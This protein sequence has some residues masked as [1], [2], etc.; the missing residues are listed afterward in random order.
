[1][2]NEMQ[3][4]ISVLSIGTR[5]LLAILE[6]IVIMVNVLLSSKIPKIKGWLY[7][8]KKIKWDLNYK[9]LQKS[10]MQCKIN[11]KIWYIM[12]RQY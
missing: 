6:I 10:L 8:A 3:W 11:V 12:L 7:L 9:K 5:D 4:C 2:Q 1:M